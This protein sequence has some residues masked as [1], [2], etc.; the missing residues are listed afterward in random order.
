MDLKRRKGDNENE[1]HNC[2]IGDEHQSNINNCFNVFDE[3]M[4]MRMNKI[5]ECKQQFDQEINQFPLINKPLPQFPF[6]NIKSKRDEM[7]E[8]F[9]KTM[10]RWIY[11]K[12]QSGDDII[13]KCLTKKGLKCQADQQ[14]NQE[15]E[16]ALIC[17]IAMNEV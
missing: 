16:F 3:Q 10:N 11:Q 4:S 15:G 1:N 13:N 2:I 14:Y 9:K 7:V 17:F 5:F 12:T 8:E 6:N